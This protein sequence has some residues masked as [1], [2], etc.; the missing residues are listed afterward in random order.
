M[1]AA[2]G[3]VD[4]TPKTDVYLEGYQATLAKYPD[5]FNSDLMARILVVDD[6]TTRAVHLNTEMVYCG[7][8]FN[9]EESFRDELA[10]ACKT[11]PEQIILSN[12]HNHQAM[13]ALDAD[14]Q[15]SIIGLAKKLCD[16]LVPVAIGGG[17]IETAFGTSRSNNYNM[18]PDGPYDARMTVLRFDNA[19]TK[20]PMGLIFSVP[21]HNTAFGNGG[22]NK[23]HW[24][25]FTCEFT[26][27]AS[28]Y[29]EENL[30]AENPEF[31]AMHINGFYGNS[32]PLING[33]FYV[34][35]IK[36]LE[37]AGYEFGKEILSCYKTITSEAE[38]G[39]VY[40]NFTDSDLLP[41]NPLD[42]RFVKMFAHVNAFPCPPALGLFE[43]F[44]VKILT[45][46]FG[47]CIFVGLNYE[48]F[49]ITGAHLKA[50]SPFKYVLPA[51]NVNGWWG[52]VP[53][54]E[55]FRNGRFEKE[56]QPWKTGF[57]ESTEELLYSY[58][59]K[60]VCRE[61]GVIMDR[62]P[63]TLTSTG[64]DGA[65]TVYYFD[66]GE[67]I[68][69]DKIVVSFE[70]KARYD[71]ASDF[72]LSLM[73]DDG[74][75]VHNVEI[76]NNSVNYLGFFLENVK[77]SKAKVIVKTAYRGGAIDGL[78]VHVHGIQFTKR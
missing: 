50:E 24:N 21:I 69:P 61:K 53:T 78:P 31:A 42:R 33:S 56:C 72:I 55:V 36:E 76:T 11:T 4:I 47:D 74:N 15:A 40:S 62:L 60:A 20:E 64:K 43:E 39:K 34:N 52:Y 19:E 3:K 5:D 49:S 63:G 38:N 48:A 27:Y 35:T 16:N 17:F 75:I 25:Q 6:G 70:Q 45:S 67:E 68:T 77:F 71:C 32:G 18:D 73:D 2:I 66:F 7:F 29:I 26:G 22:D 13:P 46:V 65:A 8:G 28:R 37:N 51:A 12:T 44:P 59:I 10:E 23:K 9:L 30:K 58:L 41:T 14:Q 54:K 1:L 57:T